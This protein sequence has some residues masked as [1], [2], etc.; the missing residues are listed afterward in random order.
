M[1]TQCIDEIWDSEAAPK[2][3]IIY[4][5]NAGV[6]WIAFYCP[7]LGHKYLRRL[8]GAWPFLSR[9]FDLA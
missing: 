6:L 9:V 4:G 8:A 1:I 5:S 2:E 7:E 3:C